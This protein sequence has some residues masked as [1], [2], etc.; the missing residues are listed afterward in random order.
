MIQIIHFLE[1]IEYIYH[2]KNQVDWVT[3]D[4]VLEYIYLA[5]KREGKTR[6][7]PVKPIYIKINSF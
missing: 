2:A 7:K 3:F 5:P 6:L 1:L 4:I